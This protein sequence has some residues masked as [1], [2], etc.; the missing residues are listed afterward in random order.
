M[1]YQSPLQIYAF[2]DT[3]PNNSHALANSHTEMY[4]LPDPLKKPPQ[5]PLL[6]H[7]PFCSPKPHPQPKL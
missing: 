1:S 4:S 7:A 2:P 3:D 6:L 5:R